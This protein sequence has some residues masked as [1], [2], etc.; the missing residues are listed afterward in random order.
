MSSKSTVRI[1][2]TPVRRNSKA[3]CPVPGPVALNGLNSWRPED[4]E[5]DERCRGNVCTLLTV[6]Y[7]GREGRR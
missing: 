3:A 5:M 6:L 1:V 2:C 7:G 4:R